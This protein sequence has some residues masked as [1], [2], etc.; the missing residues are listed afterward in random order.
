MLKT[1]YFT[2]QFLFFAFASSPLNI[3][4]LNP[5]KL[6]LEFEIHCFSAN[7]ENLSF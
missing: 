4:L 1:V 5:Y 2:T 7:L 3:K 6:L